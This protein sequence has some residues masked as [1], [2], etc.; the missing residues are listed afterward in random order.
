MFSRE[1]YIQQMFQSGRWP[2]QETR[3]A[4]DVP[5]ERGDERPIASYFQLHSGNLT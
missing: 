2:A 5:Y 4:I 1:S 3:R